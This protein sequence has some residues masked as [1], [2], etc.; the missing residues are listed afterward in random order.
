MWIAEEQFGIFFKYI[1]D[2]GT[3]IQAKTIND[4][5]V[6]ISFGHTT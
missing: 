2:V 4:Q 5:Y 1:V 6:K 3:M